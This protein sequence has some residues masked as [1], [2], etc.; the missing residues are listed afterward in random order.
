[1]ANDLVPVPQPQAPKRTSWTRTLVIAGTTAAVLIGAG[2]YAFASAGGPGG[3]HGRFMRDFIEYRVDK[4]LTGI[5]AN[6][7]QKDRIKALVKTTMDEVRPNRDE[8]RAMREEVMK[9]L[10]AP[11]IDREAIEKLRA[12]RIAEMDA[13]S[14]VVAKAVADAAE[15]LTPDQRKKLV[16]EF[17]NFGPGHHH[18]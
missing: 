11:T 2:A 3:W 7:E 4:T 16:E 1:M 8:R 18:D 13:K 10:E 5:G 9:L 15:I 6:D 17:A 14:K 12:E